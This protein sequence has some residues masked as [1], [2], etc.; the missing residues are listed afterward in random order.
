MKMRLH[1]RFLLLFVIIT[2]V[3]T[4]FYA[5]FHVDPH[6]DGIILKPAVD[7]LSGKKLFVDT[8]TQYGALST[9]IHVSFLK[10]FGETLL[11]QRMSAVAAYGII[12][13]FFYLISRK[14]FSPVVSF[15][16]GLLWLS[17]AYF[18]NQAIIVPFLAWSSVYALL[19]QLIA[20]WSLTVFLEKRAARY[21][22]LTGVSCALA[23]WAR[24]PVGVFLTAAI[25]V[26]LLLRTTVLP[27]RSVQLKIL[28][29]FGGGVAVATFPFILWLLSFGG[30][31][32]WWAQSIVLA[33]HFGSRLSG[34]FSFDP[35]LIKLFPSVFESKK[36]LLWLLTIATTLII[37]LSQFI[38]VAVHTSKASARAWI[39]L[40]LGITGLASWMQFFPAN[41]QSHFFW[42]GTPLLPLFV[43]TS[44]H[45]I[46]FVLKHGWEELGKPKLRS[47][48][49]ISGVLTSVLILVSFS[50][51][52]ATAVSGIRYY[53]RA[54]FETLTS[55]PVLVSM[56]VA[57]EEKE[58]LGSVEDK[59]Q[60]YFARYPGK[61]YINVTP[62]ALYGLFDSH[63]YFF[64]KQHVYWD[65]ASEAVFT[66]YMSALDSYVSAHR[67]LILVRDPLEFEDY[68]TIDLAIQRP[69]LVR[70]PIEDV[71]SIQRKAPGWQIDSHFG[72]IHVSDESLGWDVKQIDTDT[73]TLRSASAAAQIAIDSDFAGKCI[74]TL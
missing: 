20:I 13:V 24:Q 54:P 74:K 42:A 63:A 6:H 37:S 47:I 19:F 5:Q 61:T 33:F 60:T 30:M 7:V 15:L 45:S 31:R 36:N 27:R 25:S 70:V 48:E 41:D 50:S 43:Y 4:G 73:I 46:T 57:R 17:T 49:I 1:I 71:I 22:F 59:L 65:W 53:T 26:F 69:L 58:V 8:F 32:D 10:V 16:V 9:L 44:Y 29:V 34:S 38:S 11:V 67:P 64:H 72:P 3:Y 35:I 68:C 23:F 21:I 39:L 18:P 2:L 14:F 51:F 52:F 66:D 62:D 28:G 55:P 12:A 40:A 56:R